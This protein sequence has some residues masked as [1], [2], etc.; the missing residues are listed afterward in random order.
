MLD[1]ITAITVTFTIHLEM[2]PSWYNGIAPVCDK[3]S[4][5]HVWTFACLHKS[6][7]STRKVFDNIT[8]SFTVCNAPISHKVA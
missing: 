3:V 6:N 7:K 5:Y 1:N 8:V 2:G 4:Q